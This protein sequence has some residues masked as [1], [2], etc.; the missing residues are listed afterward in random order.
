VSAHDIDEGR[1]AFGG[2]DG[3]QMA[4]QPD[5][6]ADDPEAQPQAC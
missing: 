2:P 6:A 4:D 3:G 1:I 5:G